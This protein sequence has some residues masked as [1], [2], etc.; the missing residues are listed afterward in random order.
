MTWR[1]AILLLV[2]TLAIAVAMPSVRAYITQQETLSELRAEAQAGREEV[3]DLTAEVARWDDPAFV[4]AQAR[5]RLAYVFPGETPYRVVDAE[6]VEGPADGSP[7]AER[8]PAAMAGQPWYDKL[9]DSVIEAGEPQ[10]NAP[11]ASP[12]AEPNSEPGNVDSGE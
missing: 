1:V 11:P 6:V 10:T 7:A 3:A 2:I 9:W 4:I 12:A 8:E 5:E